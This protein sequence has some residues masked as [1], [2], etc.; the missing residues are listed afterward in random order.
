MTHKPE[1]ALDAFERLVKIYGMNGG[2][3]DVF[4]DMNIVWEALTQ[5]QGWLPIESAPEE[6][7]TEILAI[8]RGCDSGK[9]KRVPL[10]M[11]ED[12]WLFDGSEL[13]YAW[14]VIMWQPMPPLPQPPEVKE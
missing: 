6:Y 7:G 9:L 10:V 12:G 5:K 11:S 13:S 4:H 2:N 8:I 1:T 14:D 3:D